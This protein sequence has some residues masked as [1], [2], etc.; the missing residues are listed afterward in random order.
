LALADDLDTRRRCTV[1]RFPL[2]VSELVETITRSTA[3][4]RLG[5]A[6]SWRRKIDARSLDRR[7]T[8]L[9]PYA[10][11]GSP[12]PPNRPVK[13]MRPENTKVFRVPVKIIQGW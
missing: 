8:R 12:L 10:S 6:G 1:T 3:T 7:I 13:A 11:R 5:F 2:M 9:G 4:L